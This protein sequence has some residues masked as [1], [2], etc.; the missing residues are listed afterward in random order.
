M[1]RIMQAAEVVMSAAGFVILIGMAWGL[2]VL[3]EAGVA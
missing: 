1:K 3:V 2:L